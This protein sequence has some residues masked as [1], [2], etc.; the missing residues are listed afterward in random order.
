M[1][2]RIAGHGISVDIAR[3]G[4]GHVEA[5]AYRLARVA[6]VM[7]DA[8]EALLFHCRDELAVTQD[9]GGDVAVIRVDPQNEHATLLRAP[10]V[11]GR[12]VQAPPRRTRTGRAGPPR[13]P[14]ARACRDPR[15]GES[16]RRPAIRDRRRRR[17]PR[18]VHW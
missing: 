10:A 6:G 15:T 16:S 2:R 17:S 1:R 9:R 4:A 3:V 7:L 12:A 8:P 18:R 11:P 14:Y 5:R 13:R